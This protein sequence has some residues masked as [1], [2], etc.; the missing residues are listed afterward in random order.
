[1]TAVGILDYVQPRH[2]ILRN[3]PIIGHLRFM[4][5]DVGPELHQYLVESNTDGRPF[6]RDTRSIIYERAKGVSDKK[7]FGTERDVYADGYTYLKHS[8][9][10]RPVADGSGAATCGSRVGGRQCTQPYSLSVLNI[11][12][13]SFGALGGHAVLAMN[14]GAQARRLRARHRRGRDLALPPRARRRPDLAD[15]HRLLR[16]P[17][18]RA[19]SFDPDLFAKNA[20]DP[21]VK[22][23][24]IKLSQ[25]AKPGH[26]G[27]LPGAKVTE[28]IAEAR[29]VT[30]GKDGLLA[31][32]PPGVLDPAR[33]DGVHRPAARAVGR[34]A[35][36][37][38]DLHR[39]AARVHGA[40]SRR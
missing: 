26:G 34:Q 4:L 17:Q 19:A 28:E 23:I 6:N 22:M 12:A 2:S 37:L 14:T 5:E 24:E 1:M 3:F 21:Q 9:A 32:L 35:G 25:G 7:P 40:S 8:I 10:T 36:R 39:R 38:Q 20:A 13:M 18:A 31:H 27:I 15:R 30:V 29:L 33:D 11:S 16:L